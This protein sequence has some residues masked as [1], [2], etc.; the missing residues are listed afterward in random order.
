MVGIG[1]REDDDDE[2]AGVA[3]KKG[4]ERG[5]KRNVSWQYPSLPPNQ[6]KETLVFDFRSAALLTGIYTCS[7]EG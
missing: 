7:S 5:G 6:K 3:E 2:S 1:K 4:V